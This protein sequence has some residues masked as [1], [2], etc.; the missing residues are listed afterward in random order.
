M[1]PDQY[2]PAEGGAAVKVTLEAIYVEVRGLTVG[3][4]EILTSD[5]QILAEQA[6]HETRLNAHDVVIGKHGERL[7]AIESWKTTEE[8]D[9]P[10]RTNAATI[11]AVVVAGLSVVVAVIA[12]IVG[13]QGA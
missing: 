1:A 4:Q 8:R 5:R 9:Q 2:P 3:M 6:K 7:T 13:A 12:I 10:P 11:A